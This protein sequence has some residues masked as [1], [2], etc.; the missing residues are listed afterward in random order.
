MTKIDNRPQ[1]GFAMVEALLVII[2]IGLVVG[3]GYW[4]ATQRNSTKSPTSS[5]IPAGQAAAPVGT[6]AAIDTLTQQ[7]AQSE[8]AIYTKGDTTDQSNAQSTNSAL[9]NLGG[10]YNE[11]N[12]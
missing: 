11:T 9:T 5:A 6:A 3:V 4:V 12:L 8:T 2:I 10:A 7:D 1:R